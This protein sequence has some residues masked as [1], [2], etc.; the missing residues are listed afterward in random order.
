M[1]IANVA[2]NAKLVQD[3][4]LV[5]NRIVKISEEELEHYINSKK[6]EDTSQESATFLEEQGIEYLTEQAQIEIERIDE[7]I[8]AISTEL[9]KFYDK[10][11]PTEANPPFGI[12]DSRN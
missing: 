9:W 2:K 3:Y 11:T 1:D 7:M 4:L 8:R 12:D 10:Q 5:L 6:V